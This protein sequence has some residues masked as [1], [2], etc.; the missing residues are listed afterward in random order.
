M[1]PMCPDAQNRERPLATEESKSKSKS[2]SK[3][4]SFMPLGRRIQLIPISISMP[5]PARHARNL[6]A[7]STERVARYGKDDWLRSQAA[8]CML[9]G[10]GREKVK[11]QRG[12]GLE[13]GVEGIP[14]GRNCRWS[15]LAN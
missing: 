5:I 7:S 4:I 1:F 6:Q 10:V 2:K 14:E 12:G 3:S 8:Q 9:L 15:G 13:P 11:Q